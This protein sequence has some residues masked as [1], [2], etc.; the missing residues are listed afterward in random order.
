M[1]ND[2][3]A[4]P[5]NSDEAIRRRF[6]SFIRDLAKNA[7]TA[8]DNVSREI[9]K[10]SLSMAQDFAFSRSTL[11]SL[12]YV[13]RRAKELEEIVN[14][15]LQNTASL[16][17]TRAEIFRFVDDNYLSQA[18]REEYYNRVNTMDS[19]NLVLM[20]HKLRDAAMEHELKIKELF[21]RS[22]APR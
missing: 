13:T 14:K 1:S 9:S 2:L 6:D 8:I 3:V 22:S 4:P 17:A 12:K 20:G 7:Q 5:D 10:D 19:T 18:D 21:E 15:T 11:I 16:E